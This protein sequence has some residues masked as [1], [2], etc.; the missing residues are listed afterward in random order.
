MCQRGGC[1]ALAG[2][3]AIAIGVFLPAT[4]AFADPSPQQ[5][6]QQIDK[7]HDELEHVIEDYN[8]ITEELAATQAAAA[9][10]EA[11]LAPLQAKLDAAQSGVGK[12]AVDRVQG[13]GNLATPGLCCRPA[14]QHVAGPPGRG[15]GAGHPLA[16]AARSP[17]SPTAKRSTRR[18]G[19]GWPT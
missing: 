11:K 1:F 8:R 2:C 7:A 17:A 10:L 13:G 19:N 16:P 5:L 18:N 6:E 3:A 4:A 15:D 14:E 12:L 9:A